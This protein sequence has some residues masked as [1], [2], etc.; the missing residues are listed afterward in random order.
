MHAV[1][2]GRIRWR[3]LG[4]QRCR[5]THCLLWNCAHSFFIMEFGSQCEFDECKQ[6][7]FLPF[8]CSACLKIYCK[9][10]RFPDSHKC[11]MWS[12]LDKTL[13][14][15]RKCNNILI[16]EDSQQEH[17]DSN[18]LIGVHKHKKSECDKSNCRNKTFIDCKYC[19]GTYCILH[20]HAEDHDCN[21]LSKDKECSAMKKI[22]IQLPQVPMSTAMLK[23]KSKRNPMLELMKLK[24]KAT[25][26]PK[27]P[28]NN[29]IY[30]TIILKK[31]YP[32]KKDVIM[33]FPKEWTI[34]R[35]IDKV[36]LM[37]GIPNSNNT[38]SGSVF[39]IFN[40][41]IEARAREPGINVSVG[42]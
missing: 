5:G 29:R 32:Q 15:C 16:H 20:R 13:V 9:N 11:Q 31:D 30:F 40:R 25:G 3:C 35:I 42:I 38:S 27:I 23:K 2:D 12:E 17:L 34:G 1:L 37:N 4:C 10:H 24:S 36:A 8:S 22:K 39:S 19:L 33:Y 14:V 26:D 21:S 6:L 18:C 7:D 28:T 41:T